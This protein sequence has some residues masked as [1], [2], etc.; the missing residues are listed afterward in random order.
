MSNFISEEERH[1]EL[2]GVYTT[3]QKYVLSLIKDV[4]T[5]TRRDETICASLKRYGVTV[6]EINWLKRTGH[7]LPIRS[8]C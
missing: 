3:R 6:A 7:Y 4:V 2:Y 8:V 5:R 1:A